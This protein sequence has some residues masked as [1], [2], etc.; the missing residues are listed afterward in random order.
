[1]GQILRTFEWLLK[2]QRVVPTT[3]GWFV[4]TTKGWLVST[5]KGWLVRRDKNP[6]VL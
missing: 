5:T 1:V 3:K 4:S 6:F 2:K